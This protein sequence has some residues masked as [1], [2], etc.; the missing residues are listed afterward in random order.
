MRNSI[1]QTIELMR[2]KVEETVQLNQECHILLYYLV[3]ESEK[4]N[5][6]VHSPDRMSRMN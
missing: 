3:V 1:Q 5:A 4:R 2:Q 6:I